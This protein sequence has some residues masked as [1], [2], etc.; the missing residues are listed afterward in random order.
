MEKLT[1]T[2]SHFESAKKGFSEQLL[3]TDSVLEEYYLLGYDT[4]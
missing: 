1:G 2:T 4:M 3:T